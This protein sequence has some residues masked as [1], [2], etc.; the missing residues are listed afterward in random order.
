[1][2]MLVATRRGQGDHPGD[3]CFTAE[4][5]PVTP[6]LPACTLPELCGCVRGF[7]G[8]ESDRATTTALVADR[9]DLTPDQLMI[10]LVE[11]VERWRNVAE[12]P[13]VPAAIDQFDEIRRV[14]DSFPVGTVLRRNGQYVAAVDAPDESAA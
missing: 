7:D 1:M 8:L 13:S 3:Y 2:R 10:L 12:P 11:A 5:E 9:T 6:L 14:A 4:G